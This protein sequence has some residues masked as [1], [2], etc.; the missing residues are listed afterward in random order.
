MT[1]FQGRF[2]D[3]WHK[4]EVYNSGEILFGL[5]VSDY[6]TLIERKKTFNLLQKLYGLYLIVNKTIDSYYEYVWSDLDVTQI[7]T[8]LSDYSNRYLK[9]VAE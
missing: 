3:L 9:N 6:P 7:I 8:D 4:Y 1:L 5:P 2:D